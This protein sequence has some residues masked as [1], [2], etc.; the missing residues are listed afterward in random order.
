M[1]VI[2]KKLFDGLSI[3]VFAVTEYMAVANQKRQPHK[4]AVCPELPLAALCIRVP[5]ATVFRTR[6]CVK[7][8]PD[9]IGAAFVFWLFGLSIKDQAEIAGQH[10]VERIDRTVDRALI[11]D[12]Q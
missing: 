9:L 7:N 8:F 6:V 12:M 3:R 2:D 10:V 4:D 5:K 1:L 11:I